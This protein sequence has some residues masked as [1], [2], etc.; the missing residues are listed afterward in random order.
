MVRDTFNTVWVALT[1]KCNC[2]CRWCYAA[3][4]DSVGSYSKSIN[5]ETL[6]YT[7]RL[8]LDLKPKKVVFIGGEPTLYMSLDDAIK[9]LNKD[10]IKVGIVTNGR[11]LSKESYLKSLIQ[12]GLHFASISIQGH[13][14]TLHDNST[15]V[16][17]SFIETVGGIKNAIKERLRFSTNTT[18]NSLNIDYIIDIV[19][20]LAH[21]G[22]PDVSFNVCNICLSRQENNI[23][24][25]DLRQAVRVIEK[26]VEYGKQLSIKTRVVTPLPRCLFSKSTISSFGHLLP[27]GPCQI[28]TGN[29]FVIDY[30]GDILPCTHLS[31][32]SY[33]NIVTDKPVLSRDDFIKK[34]NS[35]ECVEIRD[36]ISRY[37]SQLCSDCG[38]EKCT[39]GCPLFWIDNE[40]DKVLKEQ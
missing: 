38:I 5:A 15:Q 25:V 21:I 13:S 17:G 33:F 23:Y 3:S 19:E 32:Y 18:I 35:P 11:R 29:N 1:Y 6:S 36:K 9:R 8:L 28:M 10:G 34:Y 37:P 20:F 16:K 12:S 7:I 39:G 26:A 31:G 40:P 24:R 4:N 14:N 27:S 2:R 30:N 22:V